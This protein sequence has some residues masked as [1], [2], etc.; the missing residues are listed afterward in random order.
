MPKSLADRETVITKK[1]KAERPVHVS[2][3]L[4]DQAEP[5]FQPT[6]ESNTPWI[7]L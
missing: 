5:N 1:R 3:R 2:L 4:K 7:A 6:T